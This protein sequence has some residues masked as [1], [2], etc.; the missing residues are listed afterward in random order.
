MNI[1]V[2][3][4]GGREHAIIWKLKQSP[5]V[6]KIYCT[7]G[8]AGICS[9]AECIN[10]KPEDITG[11][12]NFAK[13][14]KIDFTVVGPEVPLAMGVVDKFISEGLKVF[15][16]AKNAAMLETSKTFAK[17][18]MQR[19]NIPSAQFR[20]FNLEQKNEAA[21]YLSAIKYPVVIKADGLAAGK[22]V[23]ISEDKHSAEKAIKEIFEDKIF[24]NAGNSIVIEDF[25]TGSEASVFAICDGTDYLVLPPA[26]DHKKILNGEKGKNTGG[27]GSF[28]PADKI[29]TDDVMKKIRERVIE[30]V[31]DNM[32]KEGNEFKGCLYC[33]LMINENNDPFVIEFNTRL[34]DPETQVVLPKIESDFLEMLLASAEG[35]IKNYNLKIN[36]NYYCSVVLASN[37][38]PDK[39]ESGKEI[40]GLDNINDNCIIFH[41]GTKCEN[42]KILSSGGRVLNVVGVSNNNLKY[43][44]D[45]A[46]SNLALINFE[47]KYYRTDIAQKGL[48]K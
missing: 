9:I 7:I 25:L 4:N 10:I 46:Y 39:Y 27:M 47:N 48:I 30:P 18:F 26:Q 28:A 24:G 20:K 16:P 40:T 6:D 35:N 37:G 43:A 14:N 17:E 31:L 32:K 34:G 42:G 15:G 3:G 41:A 8:N 36:N 11:L 2:I 29:V 13:A 23:I 33:G 1:L 12:I 21:E 38:Y 45:N 5:R 22:G 44:I 19:Y